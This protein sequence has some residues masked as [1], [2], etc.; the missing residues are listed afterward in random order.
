MPYKYR[1]NIPLDFATH[2]H[3]L[4]FKEASQDCWAVWLRKI[5]IKSK[6]YDMLVKK[7]RTKLNLVS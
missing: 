3:L 7:R 2:R 5:L 6:K 4:R 1:A